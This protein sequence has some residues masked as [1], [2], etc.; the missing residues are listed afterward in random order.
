M[1]A[2]KSAS[3]PL[4][5]LFASGTQRQ[6]CSCCSNTHTSFSSTDHS[7]H[8]HLP[9]RALSDFTRRVFPNTELGE[10]H[11]SAPLQNFGLMLFWGN[12]VSS[13]SSFCYI[14]VL[15]KLLNSDEILGLP[16]SYSW[17]VLTLT[18]KYKGLNPCWPSWDKSCFP[19]K[20]PGEGPKISLLCLE[21][22]VL[23]K[24][25][26]QEAICTSG[27]TQIQHQQHLLVPREYLC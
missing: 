17:A 4:G 2:M 27:V 18:Q 24:S 14:T 23:S 21:T 19:Q 1:L 26:Q 7:P 5:Q 16:Y 10:G 11:D 22:R 6:A 9:W 20:N 15:L 13:I 25:P 12:V 3:H 8:K